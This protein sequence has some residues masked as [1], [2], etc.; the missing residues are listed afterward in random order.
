MASKGKRETVLKLLGVGD[1]NG[2]TPGIQGLMEERDQNKGFIDFLKQPLL[3]ALHGCQ[4]LHERWGTDGETVFKIG[5]LPEFLGETLLD[6]TDHLKWM[7]AIVEAEVD[8]RS[9]ADVMTEILRMAVDDEEDFD[10]FCYAVVAVD[11]FLEAL[12]A[13]QAEFMDKMPKGDWLD[14]WMRERTL[15]EWCD[16]LSSLQLFVD[17]L[18]AKQRVTEKKLYNLGWNYVTDS[19]LMDIVEHK[20]V[21]E[22]LFDLM[23]PKQTRKRTA[24]ELEAAEAMAIAKSLPPRGT[25][26]RLEKSHPRNLK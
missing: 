3:L 16:D 11:L 8:N 4:S 14:F 5:V 2:P 19:W 26:P 12:D 18:E 24:E 17:Q 13:E 25:F 20:H 22:H 7:S 10:E 9:T 15:K 6:W 1:S 21:W 23:I